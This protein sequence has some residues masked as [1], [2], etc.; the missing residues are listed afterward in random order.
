MKKIEL[1][2]PDLIFV[3]NDASLKAIETLLQGDITLVT[4]VK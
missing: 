2:G 4:N 1:V 3:Q